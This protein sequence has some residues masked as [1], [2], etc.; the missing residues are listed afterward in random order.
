MKKE[1]NHSKYRNQI[2][3][4]MFQ[5]EVFTYKAQTCQQCQSV[6][7]N[8]KIQKKFNEW[9]VDLHKNKRHL[10]QIQYSL[11]D[12][13]VSCVEKLNERF[14]GIDQSLLVRALVMVNLEIVEE[15]EKILEV[16]EENLGS[17]DYLVLIDGK[18]HAKK[19]QFKPNGMVD[20]L[21]YA[22]MLKMKPGKII[23][24]SL[25]R[26]LLLS[27]RTDPVMKEFWENTILK[28]IEIILKA[29]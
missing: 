3:E 8:N 13:A 20:I 7:W 9:L 27:I 22:D 23:E 24:D 15:D 10:F 18:Q 12:H 6:L 19:L 26:I 1:C 29:A 11:S 28:N 2:H 14:P 5:G 4:R 25:Y 17:E 16:V 21:T